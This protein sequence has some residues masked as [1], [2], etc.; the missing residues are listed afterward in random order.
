MS[1]KEGWRT[2]CYQLDPSIPWGV[3]SAVALQ[4]LVFSTDNVPI[5]HIEYA[6]PYLLSSLCVMF[7]LRVLHGNW[8]LNSL[9]G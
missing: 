2:N 8:F 4:C 7:G 9:G 1:L 3:I 5:V 6:Q